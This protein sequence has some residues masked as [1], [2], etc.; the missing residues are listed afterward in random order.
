[1]TTKAAQQISLWKFFQQLGKSFM[2]PG[3]LLT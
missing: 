2:L 1:M 3:A